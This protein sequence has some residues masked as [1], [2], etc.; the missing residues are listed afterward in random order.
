MALTHGVS[1]DTRE[2]WRLYLK[3]GIEYRQGRYHNRI[4]HIFELAHIPQLSQ[5]TTAVQISTFLQLD[6]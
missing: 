4:F 2:V 1:L 5:T 3:P 6:I